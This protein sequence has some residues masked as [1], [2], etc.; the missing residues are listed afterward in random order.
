M[1]EGLPESFVLQDRVKKNIRIEVQDKVTG[2][3]F[4]VLI[5]KKMIYNKNICNGNFKS[6]KIT[7]LRSE[8]HKNKSRNKFDFVPAL[9]LK[10]CT[11]YPATSWVLFPLYGMY[12]S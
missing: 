7:K 5:I 9:H 10:F 2:I 6:R 11:I 12:C 3:N 1:E 8:K 4:I